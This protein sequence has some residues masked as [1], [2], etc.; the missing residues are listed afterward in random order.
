MKM[1]PIDIENFKD[2]MTMMKDVYS[3]A[4]IDKFSDRGQVCDDKA[5]LATKHIQLACILI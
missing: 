2:K 1:L 4:Q 5:I 3:D